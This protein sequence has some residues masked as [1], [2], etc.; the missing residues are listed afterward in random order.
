MDDIELS[1]SGNLKR[2]QVSRQ[3]SARTS[4]RNQA[5]PPPTESITHVNRESQK[6]D[7]EKTLCKKAL[8]NFY[9]EETMDCLTS[10][11]I[12]MLSDVPFGNAYELSNNNLTLLVPLCFLIHVCFG[13]TIKQRLVL[14]A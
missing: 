13:K 9:R 3:D 10:M 11:D 4:V 1:L 2:Q 8:P 12:Q 7:A 6:S 14:W 5:N